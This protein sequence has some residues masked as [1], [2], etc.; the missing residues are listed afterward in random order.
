[1]DNYLFIA[2]L[3][4]K[5]WTS[6]S[7]YDDGDCYASYN[8]NSDDADYVIYDDGVDDYYVNYYGY[9]DDDVIINCEK[10]IIEEWM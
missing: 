10:R 2:F 4:L 6:F 3:I 9:V 5:Q 8:D 1:M 7:S